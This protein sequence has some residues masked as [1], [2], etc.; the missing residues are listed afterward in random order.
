MNK[1]DGKYNSLIK[2]KELTRIMKAAGISRISP[3]CFSLLKEY[4]R[5]HFEIIISM[6]KEE[7]SIKGRKTLQME[8]INNV[9]QNMKK[10]KTFEI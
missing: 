5:E 9:L 4:A 8:D 1:N 3:N 10:E 2:R 6:L 7:I